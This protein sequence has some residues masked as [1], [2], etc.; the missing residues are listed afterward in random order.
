V[1][2]PQGRRFQLPRLCSQPRQKVQHTPRLRPAATAH[3]RHRGRRRRSGTPVSPLRVCELEG[4]GAAP[5]TEREPTTIV[6]R[7]TESKR[8]RCM[9]SN[10]KGVRGTMGGFEHGFRG[11]RVASRNCRLIEEKSHEEVTRR[12]GGPRE[13]ARRGERS[14][15][16]EGPRRGEGPR[17]G[18]GPPRRGERLWRG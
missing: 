8:P 18:E 16:A 12:R 6:W 5:R 2:L 15:H 13:G 4:L 9:H 14:R 11:E 3:M 7:G 17:D 10:G 1:S